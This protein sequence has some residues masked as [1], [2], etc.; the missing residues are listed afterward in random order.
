MAFARRVRGV[1]VMA[2]VWAVAWLLVMLPLALYSSTRAPEVV[3]D[4]LAPPPSFLEIALPSALW[5]AV[6]G[7]LFAGYV[8]F[9][10]SRRG[11]TGLGIRHA[12]VC[13]VLT[14]LAVPFLI[15]AVSP[16]PWFAARFFVV[17][18]LILALVNGGLAA[19]TIALAKRGVSASMT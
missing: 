8:A 4:V 13:A 15:V 5:G 3:H 16:I 18:A 19:G 1:I 6:S 9:R 7:A 17:P 12:V 11:W 10:G 14:A 2:F